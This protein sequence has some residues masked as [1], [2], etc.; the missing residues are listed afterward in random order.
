MPKHIDRRTFGAS[1][2][3]GA[4][5]AAV[6]SASQEANLEVYGGVIWHA[7]LTDEQVKAVYSHY[8][9]FGNLVGIPG[10]P[11]PAKEW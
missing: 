7:A 3:A 6:G 4:M 11:K 10:L 1:L 8:Q 2:A 9:E 5:G